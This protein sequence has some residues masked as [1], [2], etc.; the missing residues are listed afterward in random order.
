MGNKI[1]TLQSTPRL[2]IQ[3]YYPNKRDEDGQ[4]NWQDGE[5]VHAEHMN[6]LEDGLAE[7][8]KLDLTPEDGSL[9]GVTS[10]GV[11]HAIENTRIAISADIS[12]RVPKQ[13]SVLPQVDK[14]ADKKLLYVYVDNNGVPSR[15]SVKD[16]TNSKIRTVQGVL[17]SDLQPG[18]YI[19]L[20]KE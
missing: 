2:Q 1:G 19:F 5:L 10:D 17:P 13:L 11:F 7:V 6:H 9:S 4:S 15:M 16:I 18:E 12:T 14:N 20:E 8:S 3:K